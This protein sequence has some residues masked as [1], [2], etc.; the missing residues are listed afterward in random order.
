[1]ADVKW[2]KIVTD[3][4]DNRKI[5]IIRKM[6]EGNAIVVTWFQI[7]CLAGETNDNG[8]VYITKDIPY[9][10]ETLSNS[11]D[12]PLP[13]IKLALDTFI[14]LGMICTFNDFMCVSNWEKYQNTD[15]L[16]KIREQGRIRKQRQREKQTLINPMSRDSHVTVTGHVTQCHATEQDKEIDKDIEKELE[17]DTDKSTFVADKSVPAPYEDIKNLFNAICVSYPK[18]T[19]MSERRKSAIRARLN[20]YKLEDFKTLFEK[21]EASAFMKGKNKN[22]WMA[23]FDWLLCDSNFAKVI[24]GN[25]DNK[26]IS[27]EKQYA[28]AFSKFIHEARFDDDK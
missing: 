20:T 14:K 3:I 23:N 26:G 16:E 10:E 8:L 21:A 12:T 19:T 6:P 1:M 13:I 7:L 25:F 2:I 5:K 17:R 9:T 27:T 11:F 4:F 24:D 22:N 15:G 18:V 28:D